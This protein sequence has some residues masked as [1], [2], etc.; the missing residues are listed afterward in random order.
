MTDTRALLSVSR[1]ANGFWKRYA[2]VVDRDPGVAVLHD[3]MEKL[4]RLA[5]PH[6]IGKP[7]SGTRSP[8]T[9][10]WM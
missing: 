10:V 5:A 4:V 1:E 9:S 7:G 3:E 2:A 8:I 6:L